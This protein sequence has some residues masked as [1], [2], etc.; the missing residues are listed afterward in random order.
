MAT[1]PASPTAASRPAP[2]GP[3][4]P[5]WQ[6][7]LFV[8]GVAALVAAWWARP[9]WPDNSA[10]RMEQDLTTA[11]QLLSRPDGDAVKALDLA[12]RA[13]EV[14]DVLPERAGEAAFFAASAHVRLAEK[15]VAVRG[16]EHWQRA[17]EFLEVA[18]RHSVPP[19]DKT[20]LLYLQGKVGFHA[21]DAH[22]VVIARL[23]EAV[24]A[25]DRRAEGYALLTQA[26]LR[27]PTPDLA[28]ALEANRKL[29]DVAEATEGELVAARLQGG[30]LLLRLGKPDEARKSL[31]SIKEQAPPP[32]LV[33]ARILQ[34][35]TYQEEKRY[36]DAVGLY[37]DVL[38]KH[39]AHVSDAGAIHY[40]L[41]LCYRQL[42][43]P[44]EAAK[45]LQECVAL[46]RGAEGQAAAILLAEV[47]MAESALEPACETL[48]TA[49]ARINKPGEWQNPLLDV[50]R[51][52]EVFEKGLT[53]FRQAGRQDLAL[54]LLEA[55]PRL[56]PA[57][58]VVVLK[59]E[60]AG[61][62]AR[63]HSEGATTPEAR[64]SA[65]QLYRA[66]AEACVKAAEVPGL[67]LSQQGEQLW[68]SAQHYL[69]AGDEAQAGAKLEQVVKLNLEPA[70]LGE[71][72]YRLGENYRAAKKG[73][74]AQQAYR[75]CME[76]DTRY[77][78][79][80]R[81]QIAMSSL[82][83][84]N[85]DDAEADLVYNLKMLRW[86]AE[87]EALSQ[88]LFALGNLL[89]NRRD[90]RRVVRYLEDALGRFK[91]NPEVTKAR[92]QLADSYRQIASLEQLSSIARDNMSEETKAHF[93]K[94]RRLWMQK[95]ADEFAALERFLETPEGKE[96]LSPELRAQVPTISA[97]CWFDAGDYGKALAIFEKLVERHANTPEGLDALGG[98][99][100]CH[101]ALGQI[102]KLQ[103][104]L[105]QIKHLL[106]QMPEKV[107]RPWEDWHNKAMKTLTET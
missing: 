42:D 8:L 97:R 92:F 21:G 3:A 84:G 43:Q 41:G 2:R 75:K 91:D 105:L 44:K 11:R 64:E 94:Q 63:S 35:R 56:T 24:P 61:E 107:R 19:E 47:R 33:K 1:T 46:S 48:T 59:A 88:S 77:S 65:K 100:A 34:A 55:Y 83:A 25:S 106:P 60:V 58:R 6:A 32:I 14:S 17:R 101:A 37:V 79:L 85:L 71:A 90:Y 39:K 4:Q 31:E 18:A 26:Y 52:I 22:A 15:A 86:E 40:N 69:A 23:E 12:S 5:L 89:Y 72:W 16:R 30:E 51:A 27:L 7:P 29:R 54:K 45:A 67:P 102:E 66:A 99:V 95:A 53:A 13:L 49:V 103:Q 62:L 81:Y 74:A 93:E 20:N 36:T 96:H 87:P 78:Y 57:T 10:R 68:A 104:R 73:L 80:A 50:K 38:A 82:E 76:F 70:R 28:K 9:Y 98:A